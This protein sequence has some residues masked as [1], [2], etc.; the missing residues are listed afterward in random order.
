MKVKKFQ[1]HDEMLNKKVKAINII[2]TP[3][4]K[5]LL[6]TG[7]ENTSNLGL[8]TTERIK[9][10]IKKYQ[11]YEPENEHKEFPNGAYNTVVFEDMFIPV[12]IDFINIIIDFGIQKDAFDLLSNTSERLE[13]GLK[14]SI[15]LIE[16]QKTLIDKQQKFINL[17]AEGNSTE[18][19]QS[20]IQN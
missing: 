10:F 8:T 6:E 18:S 9:K 17:I 4:E 1:T 3:E 13:E 15:E 20:K 2:L 5:Q 14:Q 11:P 12:V 16:K 7:L 19:T